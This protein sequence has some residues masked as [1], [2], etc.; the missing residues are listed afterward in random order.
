VF[1]NPRRLFDQ[2]FCK[3]L[4]AGTPGFEEN[5]AQEVRVRLCQVYALHDRILAL[6]RDMFANELRGN[7]PSAD[8]LSQKFVL[9][10]VASPPCDQVNALLR[11]FTRA[12]EMRILLE[13]FYYNASR[14]RD[15][16]RDSGRG[17]PGLQAF[18]SIGVRD[19]RNHLVEH[20]TRKRGVKVMA[21]GVG[22]PVGPQLKP[23][24]RS[25]DPAGTLDAGL[26]ANAR[27]FCV[28]L[29]STLRAAIGARAV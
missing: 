13:A 12:D 5:L 1:A 14:I 9:H 20:P 15:L 3:H 2:Y 11:P 6:E 23:M 28:A 22:G 21:V 10:D 29:E 19:V 7:P 8:P 27:E 4:S 16:F 18:E 24:R 26:S 25:R 17:L